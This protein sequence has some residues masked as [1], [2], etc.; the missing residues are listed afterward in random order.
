MSFQSQS[1]MVIHL[2]NQDQSIDQ[3]IGVTGQ[4]LILPQGVERDVKLPPVVLVGSANDCDFVLKSKYISRKQMLITEQKKPFKQIQQKCNYY[5][6]CLSL[7]NFTLLQYPYRVRAA[8]G[9]IFYAEGT[10]YQI[11][12]CQKEEMLS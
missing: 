12:G 8:V 7:T 1:S 6:V 3:I 4:K 11:I 2:Q 9:M 10:K 5:I